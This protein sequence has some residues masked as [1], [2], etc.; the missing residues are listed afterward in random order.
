MPVDTYV[1][2][3]KDKE[4]NAGF[5]QKLIQS[6]G[7]GEPE[8]ARRIITV[9]GDG[10][11]LRG[12]HL[13]VGKKVCGVVP[14][15]SNSVAFWANRDIQTESELTQLFRDAAKHFP[16]SPLKAEI[17]F[18][19]GT[20]TI[21]YAFND[22]SVRGVYKDLD[23]ALK[24]QFDLSPIDVSVQSSLM[25]LKVTFDDEIEG[26]FRVMGTG[27]IFS[28]PYGSTAM[29]RNYGGPSLNIR[30]HA[31]V[32][33][34]MGTARPYSIV[35]NGDTFFELEVL[36]PDKRPVM[37]TFDSFGVVQNEHKSPIAKIEISKATDKTTDLVL[38]H[39]PATRAYSVMPLL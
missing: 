6:I 19:D 27:A 29:N 34:G 37:M 36:S 2:Y 39:S 22:V 13:G 18:E 33:T 20:R 17:T 23:P 16:V 3:E 15:E 28:T 35:N 21:R 10:M 1:L 30:E 32:L 31:I 38:N 12:L 4:P 26:P 24:E 25:S 5:A 9:G 8:T 11:L 7:Q 14:P